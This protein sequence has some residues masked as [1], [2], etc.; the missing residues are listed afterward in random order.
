MNAGHVLG[1][2][3][4]TA[5]MS[6]APLPPAPA[7][8][9]A[10]ESLIAAADNPWITPTERNGFV[11]TPN[12]EATRAWLER[13]D[14]ASPLIRMET[15]GRTP[16][17][18]DMLVVYASAD[19]AQFDPKKPV[20]LIQA[21]IH[22]GEI[23]GKEAGMM[24][25]RDICFGAKRS[26]LDHVNL[27]FIP[28]FNIDGHERSGP[29]NRPNQRGPANMGW[30]NTAQNLNLNRDYVKMDA[31]EMRALIALIH[32]VHPDLYLDIHVT[33]GMDYQYDIP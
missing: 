7:W 23:D 5:Q 29:F 2:I 10:S 17:G 22:P 13:L 18:R 31:P 21:G 25:L 26:L 9:G 33:D 12:Y 20:L 6:A 19:G 32:R 4:M 28:I 3:L 1:A 27:V 15:F 8:H 24:L 11:E 14:A 16:Q 30:R